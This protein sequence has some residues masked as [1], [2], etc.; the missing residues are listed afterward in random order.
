MVASFMGGGGCQAIGELTPRA[1]SMDFAMT[2]EAQMWAGKPSLLLRGGPLRFHPLL[3]NLN[4]LFFNNLNNSIKHATD[5]IFCVQL[6]QDRLQK[7]SCHPKA[8]HA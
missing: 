4:L 8:V 3:C 1:C 5:T 2:L 6:D 7:N